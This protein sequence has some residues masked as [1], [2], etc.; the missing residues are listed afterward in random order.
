MIIYTMYI[1]YCGDIFTESNKWGG[2][3][4]N[5]SQAGGLSTS[6]RVSTFMSCY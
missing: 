4:V 5:T 1:I 3:S 6:P 2:E